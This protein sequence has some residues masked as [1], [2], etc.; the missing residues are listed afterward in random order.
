M[1]AAFFSCLSRS[2]SWARPPHS[3]HSPIMGIGGVVGG[4]LHALL[5]PEHGLEPAC[6]RP[7]SGTTGT[8]SAP[9]RHRDLRGRALTCGLVAAALAVGEGIAADVLL[10][11][12]GIL[13]LLVVAMWTPTYLVWPLAVIV[14][15]TLA[16]DSAPRGRFERRGDADAHR[17]RHRR[18]SLPWRSSPKFRSCCEA[19]PSASSRAWSAR[20]S[21]RSRS[22]CSR[23]GS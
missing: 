7:G 12:T 16:L 20:G 22:W 18:R 11:A 3:A 23:C 19:T 13:G 2:F 6:A 14:G 10:A 21:R 15:L 17:Q 5:I 8:V 9:H 1:A 4:V